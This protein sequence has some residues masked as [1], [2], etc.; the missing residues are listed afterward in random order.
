V[1]PDQYLLRSGL[2]P[3]EFGEDKAAARAVQYHCA[4]GRTATGAAVTLQEA[5]DFRGFIALTIK[6][7]E[8]PVNPVR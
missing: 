2:R 3:S 6:C 8:P 1:H 5:D 4:H 7:S